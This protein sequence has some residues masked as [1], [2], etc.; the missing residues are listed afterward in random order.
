M[1]FCDA[2]CVVVILSYML[3]VCVVYLCVFSEILEISIVVSG[4]V[5]SV[6]VCSD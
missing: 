2:A 3:C 1:Y 4:V 6:V 5:V